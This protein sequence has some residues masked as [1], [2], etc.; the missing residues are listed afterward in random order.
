MNTL[1]SPP[2]ADAT[3]DILSAVCPDCNTP[4]LA[5]AEHRAGYVWVG[6]LLPDSFRGHAL[7]GCDLIRLSRALSAVA[8]ASSRVQVFR[9]AE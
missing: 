3:P 6:E 5:R 8:M 4:I 2:V 9:I 1:D 7:R